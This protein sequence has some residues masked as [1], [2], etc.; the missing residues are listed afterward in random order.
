MNKKKLISFLII[1]FNLFEFERCFLFSV[2]IA[3]YNAGKYLDDSICSLINQTIGFSK[4]EIILVNDGST[5]QTEEICLQYQKK[6]KNNI[7]YIKIKHSG[8]SKA[9]NEGMNHAHG[10][11][12]NFLDA[13]DKWD[14]Q[15]FNYINLFFKIN[16]DIDFVAGRIKFFE[17]DKKYHPLD[18]KFYKTRVVNLSQ[19]YNSIQL[20]ASSSIF[21]KSSIAGK[22][23]KEDV[24]F[25]EDSLFVNNILL[26]KPIMGL[27]KEAI[28]YYRRRTDF[29]SAINNQKKNLN[30]YTETLNK[31]S[32]FLINS[33]K[34]LY[35]YIVPF[36][37]FLIVYDLFWRIQSHAFEFLDYKN[38]KKYKLIIEE[39]LKELDDKYIFEQ[40]I[41]SYRYKA[42]VLSKKYERDIRY[43]IKLKNN[44]FVYSKYRL[45]DLKNSI[46]ELR[47]INIKNNIIYLEGIDYLWLPREKYTYFLK[48]ENE[49]FYPKYYLNP[50]YHFYTMY[51]L[52]QKGRTIFF[53]IHIKLRNKPLN[54]Y[55]YISF[56]NIISEIFPSLGA[57]SHIP[58]LSN[59]YF[60]SEKFIIRLFKKRLTIF[61]YNIKL[62]EVFENNYCNE[63]RQM[64]KD[65]IINLRKYVK[66]KNKSKK[67]YEIWIINDEFDSAGDNGEYFFRY[68]YLR[69][70]KGIKIYFA[71]QKDCNDYK[72]LKKF[73]NILDLQSDE[74]RNIF[75][76]SDKIISSI[77]DSWVIN[78]FNKDQNYIRDLLH[79]DFIFLRSNI[80]TNDLTNSLN[81]FMNNYSLI[82]STSKKEYKSLLMSNYR[83]NENNVILTGMPKLDYLNA[84]K[85]KISMEKKIIIIPSVRGPIKIDRYTK[86]NQSFFHSYK[87]Y[88]T[89]FFEFY[90]SLINNQQLSKIMNL[91]NYKGFLCLHSSFKSEW[92]G[93]KQNELFSIIDK[94]DY[95]K[96]LLTA[97]LFI[98]DYS[99][100]F[101]YIGYIKKPVIYAHF[102]YEE[103]LINHK[104]IKFNYDLDGFGPVC[105]NLNCIIAQ[106]KEEIENKCLMK[107]KFMK[108]IK[109]FFAFPNN[110]N[111]ERIFL[112][113]TTG[114]KIITNSNNFNHII[115]LIFL[116]INIYKYVYII[117]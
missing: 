87:F 39:L 29:S 102:D 49:I 56:M 45:I 52:F 82:I 69:Q 37:Q 5:D 19:E 40:K 114:R 26:I 94:C 64:K 55:F 44:Y 54:L 58:S 24:F 32:K 59:G 106:I 57:F 110:N 20:S 95:Q 71:I 41:F 43:D 4:I 85:S 116:I 60:V 17:E 73:G 23:F 65:N 28:Y 67:K 79:F 16:K 78:P 105:K 22:Y 76:E 30:F 80:I 48:C 100:I 91:H 3:I 86:N 103:Y 104:N 35:N 68:L 47:I 75:I 25:C 66:H 81:R 10:K 53:E 18:Y 27:I 92:I 88:Y 93:F 109:K 2:I 84:F 1:F 42:F 74:Y 72:R 7:I 36:I 14:Y 6:Y 113:I 63:L 70:P 98:I 38:F 62:E 97:S 8:V 90:N 111:N 9:R 31:V 112:K 11:F 101:L 15:A 50:K 61:Q 83:Y 33:S 12:I 115:L 117:I 89:K 46:I 34:A 13:D 51:G 107:K 108:K 21:R 77:S 96:Q 99:N